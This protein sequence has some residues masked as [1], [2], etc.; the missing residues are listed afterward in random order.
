ML[1]YPDCDL[2]F[3]KHVIDHMFVDLLAF[4]MGLSV[5]M[6]TFPDTVYK[7]RNFSELMNCLL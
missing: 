3:L 1:F 6:F 7:Y 2:D 5:M 4:D